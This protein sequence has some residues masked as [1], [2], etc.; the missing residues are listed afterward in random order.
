[1]SGE[2]SSAHA[3]KCHFR[4]NRDGALAEDEATLTAVACSTYRN[5]EAGFCSFGRGSLV[6]LTDCASDRDEV[7]CLVNSCATMRAT[8]VEVTGCTHGYEVGF[9]GQ[10]VLTDCLAKS[11]SSV[12]VRVDGPH[13]KVHVAGC[14]DCEG[15]PKRPTRFAGYHAFDKAQMKVSSSISEGD[16]QGCVAEDEAQLTMEEVTVEGTLQSGQLP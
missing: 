4:L 14:T 1:M 2:G 11:C 6:E 5:A 16:K 9:A 3:T 8:R 13:A 10:V 7:G 15:L 12:G